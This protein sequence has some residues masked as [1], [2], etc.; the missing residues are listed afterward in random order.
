MCALPVTS[1]SAASWAC[2]SASLAIRRPPAYPQSHSL[3]IQP[4]LAQQQ[5]PFPPHAPHST[6]LPPPCLSPS[7][8]YHLHHLLVC[9]PRQQ[10]FACARAAAA[11]RGERRGMPPPLPPRPSPSC[12][13]SATEKPQWR[14]ESVGDAKSGARRRARLPAHAAAVSDARV[15]HQ[16][17]PRPPPAPPATGK[18]ATQTRAKRMRVEDT[19]MTR[20]R[21]S[22]MTRQERAM[23]DMWRT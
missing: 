6:P 16:H 4:H 21:R 11:L 5:H 14:T 1:A 3:Q 18:E 7:P 9:A 13:Q 20:T 12:P 17:R 10:P 2:A 23:G 22:K 8:A 15:G 19:R